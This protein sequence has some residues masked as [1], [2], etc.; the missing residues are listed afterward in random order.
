MR[1]G[2]GRL[3]ERWVMGNTYMRGNDRKVIVLKV[4]N[5]GTENRPI[6]I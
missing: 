6:M 2:A 1:L 4:I 5:A 3:N